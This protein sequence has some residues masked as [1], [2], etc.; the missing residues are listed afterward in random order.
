MST[1]WIQLFKERYGPPPAPT[2]TEEEALREARR[3]WP[4]GSILK[5]DRS[6][7]EAS[8]LV[9][10]LEMDWQGRPVFRTR[11]LG[12][13]W[14]AAFQDADCKAKIEQRDKANKRKKRRS[15]LEHLENI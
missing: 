10:L 2:M 5:G 15:F 3:R 14:E 9:G 13:S 1:G 8:C 12:L 6:K 11:G 4:D 7:G